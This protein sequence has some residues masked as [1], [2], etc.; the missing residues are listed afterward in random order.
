MTFRETLTI[1]LQALQGRDLATL[2]G[3]VSP[4]SLTLITASGRVIRTA[5]EFARIH[6]A[7]FSSMSWTMDVSLVTAMDAH[8]L[9]VATLLLDYRDDP[10]DGPP[11]RRKSLLTLV[12]ALRDGGWELVLD[13]N[14]PIKE[15][16]DEDEEGGSGE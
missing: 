14:T 10:D 9:G 3:T 16:P 5:A 8:S 7:W 4:D 2:M 6:Q 1:H 15:T 13:Q 11:V 12:F